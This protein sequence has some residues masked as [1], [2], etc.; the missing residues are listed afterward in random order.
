MSVP[1]DDLDRLA[2]FL[3]G[4]LDDAERERLVARLGDDEVLYELF[5]EARAA[6]AE[7]DAAPAGVLVQGP[8]AQRLYRARWSLG[9]VAAAAVVTIV[10]APR[11]LAPP[12]PTIETLTAGLAART[13]GDARTDLF[14]APWTTFRGGQGIVSTLDPG[15]A[16]RLGVRE[17]ALRVA[18]ETDEVDDAK[19]QAAASTQIL[20][21]ATGYGLFAARYEDL[22]GKLDDGAPPASLLAEH[23][24][25]SARLDETPSGETILYGRFVRSAWL[26]VRVGELS[27]FDQRTVRA[28]LDRLESMPRGE[29]LRTAL[30]PLLDGRADDD[31]LLAARRTLEQI[32]EAK[33]QPEAPADEQSY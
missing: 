8:W 7:L 27:W 15:D 22:K 23:A 12:P 31:E 33:G 4:A 21:A 18:L 2:A 6:R 3:D 25:L 10:F 30:E 14:V 24:T 1:Y 19:G 11:L 16:F 29:S 5:V 26:A 28:T 17:V 13:D 32:L 9:L 20:D